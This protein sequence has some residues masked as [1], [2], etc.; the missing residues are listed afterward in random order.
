MTTDMPETD[1]VDDVTEDGTETEGGIARRTVLRVGAVGGLGLGLATAQGLVV[2][3]LQQKGLWSA[4]GVFSASATTI[5]DLLLYTEAFP[6]SPLIL[7]PFKDEL[8][9]PKALA[10]EQ[11]YQDWDLPP[12]PGLGQQNSLGN[13]QHQMWKP[14]NLP[15]YPDPIVYQID[16]RVSTHSFTSSPVLP[17][18]Q[19][20]QAGRVVRRRRQDLRQGRPSYASAQHHLRV[21]RAVPG[22]DDQRRVRQAGAGPVRATSSTRTPTTSTARTSARRTG[23]S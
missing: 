9:I 3:S 18:D 19:G 11:G 6:T 1:A 13:E 17:I 5:G 22:P 12:G 16:L 4:D 2:P 10:P 23:R 14:P 21:Q 20:R 8:P 15:G 7:E